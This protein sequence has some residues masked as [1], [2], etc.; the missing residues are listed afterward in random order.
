MNRALR[1]FIAIGCVMT[2]VFLLAV[3]LFTGVTSF[4]AIYP[5]ALLLCPLAWLLTGDQKTRSIIASGLFLTLCIIQ[6]IVET[7]EYLW[8]VYL[9][10]VAVAWPIVVCAGKA[11]LKP[12]FA[13]LASFS[14][15]GCYVLLN[16]YFEP[17]FIWCIFPTFALLW[18]PIGITFGRHPHQ[19]SI[20]GSGLIII[21]FAAVNRI[22][23]PDC[24]WAIHPIFAVL[25][26]PMSLFLAKKPFLFAMTGAGVTILYFSSVNYL[27][28]PQ[29]LWA[30]YPAFAVSWWPLSVYY[31]V[32]RLRRLTH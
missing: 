6:N 17:R 4:W 3:N 19:L 18:W 14:L 28:S 9:L 22:T 8:F 27:V 21:F 13:Y 31:F 25:W 12:V 1:D 20:I 29:H 5:V 16:I 30:V 26:W 2:G 23:S 32:H 24:F 10:P 7:P 15:M 11:A